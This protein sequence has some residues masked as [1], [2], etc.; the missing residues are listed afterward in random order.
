MSPGPCGC[1]LRTNIRPTWLFQPADVDQALVERLNTLNS[2]LSTQWNRLQNIRNTVEDTSS[3]AEQAQ[4]RVQDAKSLT[5][6][7]QR[8]LERAKEAVSKV[9]SG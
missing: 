4:D 9:V 1:G 7:A 2:S 8:E 5:E 6:R 3:R